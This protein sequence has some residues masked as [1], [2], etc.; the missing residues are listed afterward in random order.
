MTKIAKNVV[1]LY[2]QVQTTTVPKNRQF[3]A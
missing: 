3:E 1:R 2:E